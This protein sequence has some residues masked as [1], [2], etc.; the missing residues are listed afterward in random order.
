MILYKLLTMDEYEDYQDFVLFLERGV[1]REL[2]LRNQCIA[3]G[4]MDDAVQAG[5]GVLT[6]YQSKTGLSALIHTVHVL[7]AYRNKGIGAALLEMLVQ[8]AEEKGCGEVKIFYVKEYDWAPSFGRILSRLG[9]EEVL[10]THIFNIQVE[11]TYLDKL[12]A[13]I[14]SLLR[15]RRG[16]L[17]PA[18]RLI[19]YQDMTPKIR[20]TIREGRGKWYERNVDPFSHSKSINKEKS[21][22]LLAHEDPVGWLIICDIGPGAVLYRD[23]FLKPDHRGTG[24]FLIMLSK[25]LEWLCDSGKITKA[26]FNTN[27]ANKNMLS[28]MPKVLEPCAYTVKTNITLIKKLG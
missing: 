15:G 28:V 26:L 21:L 23:M 13:R 8:A 5:L 27:S 4:V 18:Y 16:N 9:F 14:R 11:K 7:P 22:I 25:G 17:P 3:L 20:D 6:F 10:R 1:V 12:L 19:P 24:L 2:F